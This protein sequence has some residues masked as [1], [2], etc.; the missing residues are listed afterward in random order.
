MTGTA[1]YPS[2][3]ARSQAL[4]RSGPTF[5]SSA[6]EAVLYANLRWVVS[7]LSLFKKMSITL[8]QALLRIPGYGLGGGAGSRLLAPD[9]SGAPGITHCKRFPQWS[10]T[11][12]SA[13]DGPG[14]TY[15]REHGNLRLKKA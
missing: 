10:R 13:V 5:S 2:P 9:M 6:R 15:H 3:I 1:A 7:S 14:V 4:F 8:M 11:F 12:L